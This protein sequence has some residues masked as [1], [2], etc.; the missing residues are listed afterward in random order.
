M[1][2][3]NAKKEILMSGFIAPA[4]AAVWGGAIV[5]VML[6]SGPSG[7]SSAYTSGQ[8]AGVA[9]GVVLLGAGVVSIRRRLAERNT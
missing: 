6:V 4:I 9:F 2:E 1:N 3:V 7:G 5:V 8:W